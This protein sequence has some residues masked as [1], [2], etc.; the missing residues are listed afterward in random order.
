MEEDVGG[1]SADGKADT[2]FA[3]ALGDA[4]EHDVGDTDCTD[5]EADGSDEAA[6][7]A[8]CAEARLHCS[9]EFLA[10]DDVKILDLLAMEK[11]ESLGL[12]EGFLELFEVVDAEG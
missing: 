5:D 1:A 9:D 8:G 4:S 6:A 11:E 12:V 7:D 10:G 3:D 2:E